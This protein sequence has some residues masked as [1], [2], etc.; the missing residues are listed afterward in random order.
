MH[1][2][3]ASMR[4][5]HGIL[6]MSHHDEHVPPALSIHHSIRLPGGRLEP[7]LDRI[8]LMS[9]QQ[10]FGNDM[11]AKRDRLKPRSRNLAICKGLVAGLENSFDGMAPQASKNFVNGNGMKYK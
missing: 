9:R 7:Q 3:T 11:K 4:M 5:L 1:A 6:L 2:A 10:T 8:S